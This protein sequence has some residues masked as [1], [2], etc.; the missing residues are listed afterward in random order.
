MKKI[1]QCV[2]CRKKQFALLFSSKDRMFG[3]PGEFF[4]KKCK[5]DL[6]FL[7]P[8]PDEA[9]LK[10]YY[11]GSDYYAYSS[12]DDK[13]FF[14]RLRSYL[15]QHY[16]NQNLLSKIISTFIHN[17]P[18][19]PS[20]RKNGKI[21]DVGCG[22]GDTLILLK[23]LGWNVFGLDIDKNAL[24]VASKRG[25]TQVVHGTYKDI[26]R[27]PDNYF[28]AIRLYH[29]IEHLDRPD[30]ALGI[31]RKKLKKNGELILGTPNIRSITQWVFGKYWLNLDTP[32]H[33][34][35][36]SPGTLKRLLIK[37]GYKVTDVDFCS[38]GGIIGSF[39]YVLTDVTRRKVDL[40]SKTWL[41]L[42]F[43]PIEWILDKFRVGDVFVMKAIK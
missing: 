23:K 2:L 14:G 28:D 11:P 21:L 29:V 3:I 13:S 33:V 34:F 16:Y 30:L 17:V 12:G 31:I 25:I 42:L 18:A 26:A 39:E 32:R 19:I 9:S 24:T 7:D 5:C 1:E 43:Y 22:T 38:G 20:W 15:V 10:K 6:V 41:I 37:E 36:F 4:I 27:F 8:M 40:L 35:I